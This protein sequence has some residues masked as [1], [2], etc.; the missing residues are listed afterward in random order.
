MIPMKA[1]SPL[2]LCVLLT[3]PASGR[4]TDLA[5]C[6]ARQGELER[7]SCYAQAHNAA[8]R[9]LSEVYRQLMNELAD[10]YERLL[11]RHAQIAWKRFSDAQCDLETYAY[12]GDP[13]SAA[14]RDRCMAEQ[15]EV[16]RDQV[17]AYR[18]RR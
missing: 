2:A 5:D 13:A 1:V 6:D 12:R 16:R 9:Q 15:M 8:D 4:A 3:L 7:R 10:D 17:E 11:F 18:S 14:M